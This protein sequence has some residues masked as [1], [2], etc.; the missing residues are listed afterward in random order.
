MTDEDRY[1]QGQMH[2]GTAPPSVCVPYPTA[3]AST[4]MCEGQEQEQ[5]ES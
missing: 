3:V 2:S 5:G 4:H 1:T